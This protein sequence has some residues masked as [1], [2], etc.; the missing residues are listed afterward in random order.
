M[1]QTWW[2]KNLTNPQMIDTFKEWIGTQNAQSKVFIRKYISSKNYTSLIDIGCGVAT[3]F[4]GYKSDR[5]PIEYVGVD[6]CKTL[7]QSNIHRGVPMIEAN[8]ENIP[9]KDNSYD[10]AFS[11][12]VLEHQPSYKGT[13]SEMIRIARKEAIHVF[14]IIPNVI[15]KINYNPLD[16]LYHNT[17]S[18][19]DIEQFLF[20]NKKVRSFE[21][22]YISDKEWSLH[23]FVN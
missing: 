5:Y 13:I 23:I 1:E 17:Y 6:S 11:R 19:S 12:H 22:K 16:N 8:C 9:V 15:E 4:E 18:R 20:Q 3:E 21:W 10:V 14:F 7:V 2:D